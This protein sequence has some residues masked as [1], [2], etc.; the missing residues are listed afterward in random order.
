MKKIVSV[1]LCL[2]MM[3]SLCTVAF[4]TVATDHNCWTDGTI[5]YEDLGNGKHRGYCT[6][7]GCTEET[8]F[9]DDHEYNRDKDGKRVLDGGTYCICGAEKPGACNHPTADCN[10]VNN[11]DGTHQIVCKCG[12]LVNA[13]A[14]C[15]YENGVCKFCKAKKPA[16][17]DHDC[18][19]DRTTAYKDLGN[20]KH[21]IYCTFDG[22][23]EKLNVEEDHNYTCDENGKNVIGGTYCICGA[24]DPNACNHPA[25]DCTY[26]KN[27]DG[28]HK[29]VCKCGVVV[30]AAEKCVYEN[31]VCKFCGAK[32]PVA[33]ATYHVYYNWGILQK[34]KDNPDGQL[35]AT[36]APVDADKYTMD[37]AVDVKKPFTN[38][39]KATDVVG[40]VFA[41]WMV[42][43]DETKVIQ[44]GDEF[45][46]AGDTTLVAK[47]TKVDCQHPFVTYKA[48]KGTRTH[49]ATCDECGA[50]VVDHENHNFKG[51]KCVD[52]GAKK[53]TSSKGGS[54]TTDTT[55]TTKSPKTGDMGVV[56]Y[57]ATALLSLSGTAVV[58]K[59]RKND[60]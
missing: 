13:A 49:S 37:K 5:G 43:G 38:G 41:G 58:I 25:T 47:W 18:W 48:D 45:Y 20:G 57:A 28:T 14:A 12:K 55:K 3:M 39:A 51:N 35:I 22:C 9:E 44:P 11:N 52:C 16:A 26:V 19:L 15:T 56:L 31:G 8:Y 21:L 32:E 34:N 17:T 23:N 50:V 4:A 24:K 30:N 6:V 1:L 36:K 7:P 46:L 10:Y 60:K 2:A 33:P 29:I 27:N 53:S 40:Y 54:T 59:K 42:N